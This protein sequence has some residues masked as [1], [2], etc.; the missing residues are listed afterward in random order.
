MDAYWYEFKLLNPTGKWRIVYE[1]SSNVPKLEIEH[2]NWLL[3]EWISEDS[4][5][6]LTPKRVI[7]NTCN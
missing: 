3:K 5:E 6:W 1:L 2:K 4:I 7:E